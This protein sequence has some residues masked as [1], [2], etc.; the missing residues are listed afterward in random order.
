MRHWHGITV[1]VAGRN[2]ANLISSLWRGG[3]EE[4]IHVIVV[5]S[6][7]EHYVSMTGSVNLIAHFKARSKV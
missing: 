3:A 7:R 1:G 4:A 5:G 2:H 6:E